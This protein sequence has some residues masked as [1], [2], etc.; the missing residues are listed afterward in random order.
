MVQKMIELDEDHLLL[1]EWRGYIEILE[2][3]SLQVIN[4]LKVGDHNQ[5][6][7]KTKRRKEFALGTEEGINFITVTKQRI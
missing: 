6:I 3:I 4:S 2:L 1:A 5:D 7:I